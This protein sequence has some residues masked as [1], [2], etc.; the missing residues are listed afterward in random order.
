MS[1]IAGILNLNGE[2]VSIEQSTGM[3]KALEKFPAND[4]QTWHNDNLF[5]GCHAQWITPESIGEQLPFYDYERRLAITADAIIDNREELF[6]LLQIDR[7]DRKKITDSQLILLA[8]HKWGEESPKFL[9]GDFAYVIWDEKEQKLFGARDFSGSRTL[10]YFK[11]GQRF[12]FCTVMKPMLG[13]PVLN[14]DL[15]EQWLA[16]FIANPSQFDSVNPSSTVYK[17][18]KQLPP[19]HSLKLDNKGYFLQRYSHLK[20]ES[21][22]KL[23]S[24]KEYEEAFTE[25]FEIAVTDRVRTYKEI[26]SH[27]SGGLDS[28]SVVSFAVKKL[29]ENKKRLYTFSYVPVDDFVDWTHKSRIANERPQIEEIVSYVGNIE[30]KFLSFPDKS[31]YSV[32][33]NS[34]DTLEMP[35]K[36][37]ENTFWLEEIYREAREQEVGVLL[38]GQRGNWSVSWGPILEYYALLFKRVQWL[39]LNQELNAFSKNLGGI[40]KKRILSDVLRRA[41]PSLSTAIS[42]TPFPVFINNNLANKTSVYEILKQNNIDKYGLEFPSVYEMRDNQFSRLYYW[43]TTGTYGAKLSTKY[44]LVDRDPTNDLR[45][46]KFCL[47]IPEEQ[48]VQNGYSR[49]LIRRVTKDL[50]PDSVRLNLQTK[51]IQGADSI[52]RMKS[53]WSNFI[54]E[55]EELKKHPAIHELI[56]MD[57]LNQ[58]LLSVKETP[59][60]ELAFEFDFKILMRVLILFRFIKNIEGR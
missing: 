47:S 40:K 25:V 46:I 2:P 53:N 5:L 21:K 49:S 13:L 11:D 54:S 10:Y 30:P 50:L 19:S 57:V 59:K 37:F 3:M 9:V 12:V 38:T 7:E 60:P 8:Y 45:V 31:P 24:N 6:Q 43:N 51:G 52:H 35:Y 56:N 44:G 23:K 20:Q 58:C 48:Y 29:K 28:S 36:Y 15:N 34:L 41:L 1:A 27:L 18:I 26:G 42:S 32:I 55:L 22:I 39:K 14:R 17:N 4:I 16:E 33:D